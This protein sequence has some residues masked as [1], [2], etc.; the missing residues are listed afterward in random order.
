[1][2][3]VFLG[4]MLGVAVSSSVQAAAVYM[5]TD[6]TVNFL[7]LLGTTSATIGIF[8]D[9][10]PLFSGA[11]LAIDP[12][13]DQIFFSPNG[14]DFDLSNSS[15]TAPFTLTL[16]GSDQFS[17][18][19]R[20]SAASPWIEPDAVV[21]SAVSDSCSL[22]WNALLVELAVDL[23]QAEPPGGSVPVPTSILLFGSGLVGLAVVARRRNGLRG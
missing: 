7:S 19:A 18:A 16:T 13:G 11:Y 23:A 14:A 22:S 1:M 5:P 21:C 9:S 4:V 12:T 10:D 3:R 17:I 20:A 15:G 2:N 8:D 6:S